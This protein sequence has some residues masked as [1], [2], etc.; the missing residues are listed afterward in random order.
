MA[1]AAVYLRQTNKRLD[2]CYDYD[3][4]E[5]LVKGVVP[6]V[7]VVV[8][9]GNG[10]R[11]LEGFVVA[12]KDHSDYSGALKSIRWVIDEVP[13]LTTSS[14]RYA[15]GCGTTIVP[16]TMKPWLSLS[17]RYRWSIGC[18]RCG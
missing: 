15:S 1:V 7:R 3:I 8:G 16:Y 9:F 5:N 6:G 14:W 10:N 13:V 12:I 18:Q 11:V 2:A 17:R 4:P